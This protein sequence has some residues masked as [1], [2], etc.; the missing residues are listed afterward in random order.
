MRR[1]VLSDTYCYCELPDPPNVDQVTK[2][3]LTKKELKVQAATKY[4]ENAGGK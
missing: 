4:F 3:I 1:E 2:Y